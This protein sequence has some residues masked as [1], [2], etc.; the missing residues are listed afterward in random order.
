MKTFGF[1]KTEW[2]DSLYYKAHFM[3]ISHTHM[4]VFSV[5]A[6]LCGYLHVSAIQT[7]ALDSLNCI[8]LSFL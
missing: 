2:V 6:F 3:F 4:P 8:I 1:K 5:H 7:P